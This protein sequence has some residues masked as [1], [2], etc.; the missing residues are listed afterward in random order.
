MRM[1]RIVRLPCCS[2][3]GADDGSDVIVASDSFLRRAGDVSLGFGV[4]TSLLVDATIVSAFD[5]DVS[6]RRLQ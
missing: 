1:K 2:S 3:S 4:T 6:L 5:D